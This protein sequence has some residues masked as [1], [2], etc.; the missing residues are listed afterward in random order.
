MRTLLLTSLLLISCSDSK[1]S[2]TD[3]ALGDAKVFGDAPIDAPD[4][5]NPATLF[6]T[7]L[8][9]D[10]ACTEIAP[11]IR[12]YTPKFVLW[13]DTATKKRWYQLPPGST[14]DTTNMD[15]WEFPV[16]TKF[17]KEFTRD[18]VRVETRLEMRIGPGTTASNWFYVSY[19]WN[20]DQTDTIAVPDGV[21]NANGTQHDI[22]SRSSCK[23]CHE[24]LIPTR[25]LGFGA[26]DL[27]HAET[28]DMPGDTLASLVAA[29]T[30]SVNPPTPSAGQLYFPIQGTTDQVKG[31]GYVFA[32]CSH[33]HNPSSTVHNNVPMELRMTV[34][35][36]GT[37]AA[38][39]PYLT[40]VNHYASQPVLTTTKT[41]T[42][43][44]GVAN[45][46]ECI[47]KAGDPMNSDMM[48]HFNADPL[49]GLHMPA[50]GSE[51][52]DPTGQATLNAWIAAP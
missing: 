33:C 14:I 22:P 13:A 52:I 25:V 40:A 26:I 43:M 48:V 38:S 32:N 15:F 18:G 41:C 21:T 7:G 9:V 46:A 28:T 39:P 4:P 35:T 51:M 16:G 11:D 37:K 31:L 1:N 50:L 23:G 3:A 44:N 45:N 27:D 36:V 17:W 30:L 10:R 24:N 6:D 47:I 8:C 20:A 5:N 34:A 12:T 2:A 19:A 29:G 49:L 42:D